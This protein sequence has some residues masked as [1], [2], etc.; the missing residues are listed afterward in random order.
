VL[1]PPTL[2]KKHDQLTEEQ[3]SWTLISL[4]QT[5][6]DRQILEPNANKASL[7]AAVLA[8]D[9]ERARLILR[10]GVYIESVDYFGQ[11]ALHNASEKN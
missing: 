9:R 11:R 1:D 4:P 10:E 7:F 5:V 6:S 2:Q 3:A 8:G